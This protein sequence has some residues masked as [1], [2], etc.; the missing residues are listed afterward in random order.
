MKKFLLVL[1]II[2]LAFQVSAQTEEPEE[3]LGVWLPFQMLPS[4]TLFSSSPLSGFGFEWEFSPL[5]FSMGMNDQISPWYAFIIEPTAR[6]T[7]SIE[8]VVAGQLFTTKMGGSYFAASGH[9]MGTIPLIERGEHLTLNLGIG[10]YRIADQ[11]RI[12]KVAGISTLFG[13]V[14]FNVKH[15]EKPTTWI[16]SLEFRIF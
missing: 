5:L 8:L 15:G 16:T 10:A 14:H 2:G 12:F 7:G 3:R 1:F 13:M 9:L 4:L 6:F 11:T